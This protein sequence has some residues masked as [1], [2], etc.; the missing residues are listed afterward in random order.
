M[1]QHLVT[2]GKDKDTGVPRYIED[3]PSG[4]ACKCVCPQCG[5]VLEAH[6]GKEQR[7]HFQHH[8]VAECKGAFESQLHLLSKAIIEEN[9][10]LML[11]PYKGHYC[12]LPPKQQHFTEVV[13]ECI[14][15][16]LQPDCLC[17]FQDEHGIEQTL[18]VEIFYSHAVD[19][20]KAQKIRERKISCIEIDVNQLFKDK[21]IIDKDTLTI[22]L[23]KDFNSRHWINHPKGHE[24]D[25]MV[26][27]IANGIRKYKNIVNSI[28][29]NS[30]DEF[31]LWLF[32]FSTYYLFAMEGYRLS[33]TDYNNML[34]FVKKCQSNY[35]TLNP[36]MQRWFVSTVQILLFHLNVCKLHKTRSFFVDQN[37]IIQK[38]PQY[39]NRVLQLDELQLPQIY[40][41][42]R[43]RHRRL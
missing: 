6:K 5:G 27:S 43:R 20:K 36:I 9:K 33:R 15:D 35:N 29:Q 11:P 41:P 18:W 13:Q 25:D 32:Q 40:H 3:V 19:E 42:S 34:S 39:I 8:S 4:L 22:F 24:A 12:C 26:L 38:L 7:H 37:N 2:Y 23:L 1:I 16:D 30:N 31:R 10:T 21:D 17:K 14:Q 28:K